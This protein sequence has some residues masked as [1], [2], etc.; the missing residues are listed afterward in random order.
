M[1]KIKYNAYNKTQSFKMLP[2]PFIKLYTLLG[3]S[4]Q[5]N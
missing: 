3:S 1:H 4:L 2:K 5:I